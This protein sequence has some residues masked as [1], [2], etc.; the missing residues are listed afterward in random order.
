MTLGINTV[1][2]LARL[3][4]IGGKLK[5]VA[6]R[7]ITL[8]EIITSLTHHQLEKTIQFE[9]MIALAEE[10]RFQE[11]PAAREKYL[12]DYLEIIKMGFDYL[13]KQGAMD[14]VKGR[15]LLLNSQQNIASS[16]VQTTLDDAKEK[17]NKV[18][19][20]HMEYAQF[21]QS[22]YEKIKKGE[23]ELS[24]DEL[25]VHKNKE[26]K[27]T[28]ELKNLLEDVQ[29][30][31]RNS[32]VIARI[33]EASAQQTMRLSLLLSA[34]V[35]CV[36]AFSII[37]SISQ[38]LKDL[39]QAAQK[40]GKQ[41]FDIHL[42]ERSKN[43]IGEV[44]RAF[45]TMAQQLAAYKKELERKNT[46]LAHN[47]H[48]TDQQKKELE[49]MN[50]QMDSFVHSIGHD[51]RAPLTSI[52][53][54]SAYLEKQFGPGLDERSR[55]TIVGIRKAAYRLNALIED[56]LNLIRISRVDNPV[57]DIH[58]E[59]LIQSIKEELRPSLE[60]SGTQLILQ[61]SIPIIPFDRVKLGLVFLNL[62]SNAVKFSSK[63]AQPVVEIA[64]RDADLFH[65]FAVKDNGMG[66]AP[67]H[68]L[69]V[70]KLF[71]RLNHPSEYQGTGAGLSLVKTIVE[72]HN[73]RAWVESEKGKG[74]TFYFTIPKK[75][76]DKASLLDMTD[77]VS[78][79]SQTISEKLES[80]RGDHDQKGDGHLKK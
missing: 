42:N 50:L 72:D 58:V 31:T 34:L 4:E 5:S 54:Y 27:L 16:A 11:M 41:S 2:G 78:A 79:F 57:E 71:T 56:L 75:M 43:E 8:T 38:P 22:V 35:A 44:S 70:F 23:F 55:Y 13:I 76:I 25:E 64:Y 30:L 63:S 15:E 1:I 65:E 77:N 62:I 28:E 14:I 69:N 45:N 53:G 3:S 40:I 47:L 51:I 74:A 21:V 10:L 68:H 9:R 59:E 19:K 48:L 37:T 7:D 20:V 46:L 61:P 52:A 73:G 36:L 26:R 39:A 24:F 33:Q 6:T 80:S 12:Y 66:I 17:L 67:E 18:E 32:L 49:K 29:Q 60:K